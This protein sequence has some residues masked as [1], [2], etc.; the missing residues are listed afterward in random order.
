MATNHINVIHRLDES[1]INKIAA[2]EI[3]QRP[4]GVAKELLENSLDAGATS[5]TIMVK[6]GGMDMLQIQDTGHGIPKESLDI[7]CERFTTS[8]VID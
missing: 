1:T 2:G 5:V 7:V 6:G 4:V 8:K 3:I